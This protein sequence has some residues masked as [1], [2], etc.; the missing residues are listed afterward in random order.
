MGPLELCDL[1]GADT[2]LH[3]LETMKKEFGQRLKPAPILEKMVKDGKLGRKIGKG[4]YDYPA[5]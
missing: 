2:V 1:A 3:G 5:K 4:F